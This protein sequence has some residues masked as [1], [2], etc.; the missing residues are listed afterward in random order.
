M[1]K[2]NFN[3]LIEDYKLKEGKQAFDAA[4]SLA[5]TPST[6]SAKLI[7]SASI[8]LGIYTIM[9]G[10]IIFF[11]S[12]GLLIFAA[13]TIGLVVTLSL[14]V[15]NS[16]RLIANDLITNVSNLLAGVLL[17]IENL[18]DFYRENS[19]ED[20][21]KDQFINKCLKEV[22]LPK[23]IE[24]IPAKYFK[25]KLQK[26]IMEIIDK[27]SSVAIDKTI[28]SN[29]KLVDKSK[30]V[31][32]N[33]AQKLNINDDAYIRKIKSSIEDQTIKIKKKCATPF[34]KTVRFA[35]LFWGLIW[36]IHFATI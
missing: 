19:L 3:Q 26:I 33:I 35:S 24:R 6:A 36:L 12:S 11:S 20:V 21:A 10:L 25:G 32:D 22:F 4:L 9:I 17:P 8:A 31:G 7:L 2:I 27:V 15:T 29:R 28:D 16:L 14:F 30:L 34:A 13:I 5:S 23:L 18:Y 1:K